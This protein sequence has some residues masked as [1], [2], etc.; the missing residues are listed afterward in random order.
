MMVGAPWLG[1][2]NLG[3]VGRNLNLALLAD[4]GTT[5]LVHAKVA[6]VDI[7]GKG[8]RIV[9]ESLQEGLTPSCHG[10]SCGF[11]PPFFLSSPNRVQRNQVRA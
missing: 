6:T 3:R 10:N 7:D 9:R 1:G 4:R 2:N 8:P 5:H 11:L